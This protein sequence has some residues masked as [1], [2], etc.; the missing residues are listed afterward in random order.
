LAVESAGR[1]CACGGRGCDVVFERW[2]NWWLV[3]AT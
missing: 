3:M 1:L 2:V